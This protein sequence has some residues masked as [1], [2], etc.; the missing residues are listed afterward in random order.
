MRR[1]A[2]ILFCLGMQLPAALQAA[3]LE[4]AGPRPQFSESLCSRATQPGPEWRAKTPDE[5]ALNEL[6]R[7][8]PSP[9]ARRLLELVG[10]EVMW[11]VRSQ[12]EISLATVPTA[13]HEANH[14]IDFKLSACNR[15]LA[16]YVFAGQVYVTDLVRG[17][18]PPYVI[19]AEKIPASHK[20]RPLG[21]YA[22]YF[23]RVK[24]MPGN[25]L[26]VLVD[27]LNAYVSTAQME[28][29]FAA[30]PLYHD[31]FG[32]GKALHLDG[33]IGGML[34]FVLYTLCYLKAVNERDPRAYQLIKRSP[35][36]IA[37]LQR[38]WFDAERIL[39]S[40]QPYSTR[41]GGYFLIDP[42][43]LDAVYS[44][45]FISELDK[46]SVQHLKQAPGA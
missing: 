4:G 7:E 42:D 18:T 26:T 29:D 35:L 32:P 1:I 14:L 28:V 39:A 40:A 31:F 16:T 24:P 21:R 6:L 19:A 10:S 46:L 3:A 11:W 12:G 13:F 9:Q 2:A 15:N 37:H 33:N 41:R 5:L 36:F 17:A 23:D 43:T 8:A 25:E 45:A 30:T 22:P 38:L 27:E 34:D 20:S 44:D